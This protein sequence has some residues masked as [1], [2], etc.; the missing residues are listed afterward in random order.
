[1]V[2]ALKS[3]P[4]RRRDRSAV[5][6]K[7]AADVPEIRPRLRFLSATLGC[8]LLGS[9]LLWAAFPPINLPYLAWLAPLPWLWLAKQPRLPG[10]APSVA[11]WVAGSIHWLLMLEGIRLAHP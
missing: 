3:S 7:S 10:R 11:L 4:N 8:G 2:N 1:M 9:L 6:E 5:A